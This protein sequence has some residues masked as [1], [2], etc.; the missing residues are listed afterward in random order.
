MG[1]CMKFLFQEGYNSQDHSKDFNRFGEKYVAKNEEWWE[2]LPDRKDYS[3]GKYVLIYGKPDQQDAE[4][5]VGKIAEKYEDN[6]Y[7]IQWMYLKAE[8]DEKTHEALSR[9][10]HRFPLRSYRV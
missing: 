7:G 5:W 10:R 9:T 1:G 4:V 8:G 3:I 6:N 2:Q